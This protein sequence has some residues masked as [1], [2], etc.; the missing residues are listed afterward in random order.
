MAFPTVDAY[1]ASFD[2]SIQKKLK[3]IRHLVQTLV[4]EATEAMTYGVPTFKF[5]GKNLIHFA[6]F[7]QHIGI[8]PTPR[9]LEHFTAELAQ[10]KTAT[11]TVQFPFEQEIPFL[12]I[13]EMVGYHLTLL[14]QA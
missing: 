6:A 12:L 2:P 7:K 4:P 10:Y 9:V 11:G 14:K 1:I 13:K 5:K 3:D 8:Y